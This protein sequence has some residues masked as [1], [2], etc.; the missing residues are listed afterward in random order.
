MAGA[1]LLDTEGRVVGMMSLQHGFGPGKSIA[2][3]AAWVAALRGP[4]T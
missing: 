4:A 1:P 3:P 2:V